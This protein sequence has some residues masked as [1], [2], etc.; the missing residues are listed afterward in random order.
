M[1]GLAETG[2]AKMSLR[3]KVLL[4]LLLAFLLLAAL[5]AAW[6]RRAGAG[7]RSG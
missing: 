2:E 3:V 4:P 1:S 7:S 5:A 6:P